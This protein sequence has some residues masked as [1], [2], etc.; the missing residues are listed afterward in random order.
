MATLTPTGSNAISLG[1]VEKES[2]S[3]ITN[4]SVKSLPFT[5]SDSNFKAVMNFWGKQMQITVKGKFTGTTATIKSSFITPMLNWA[6]AGQQTTATYVD[7]FGTSHLVNCE[8]FDWDYSD[9]YIT[10]IS[11]T[12]NL[13]RTGN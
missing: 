13:I 2:F 10:M 4:L 5:S 3:L 8:S 11:Y 12:L 7:G 9:E 1:T 6:D